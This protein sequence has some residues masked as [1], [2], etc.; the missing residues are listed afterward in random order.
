MLIKKSQ[1]IDGYS[2]DIWL[3]GLNIELTKLFLSLCMLFY[4]ERERG[5]MGAVQSLL[6][7]TAT[8]KFYAIPA[9]I[10]TV[11][12]AL[13]FVNIRM[14]S[15]PTYRV[16]I[17]S[18]VIFSGLLLNTFFNKRLR[19]LQWLSL[20]MLII[21]C[22]TEQLGS[23]SLEGG[24]MIALGTMFVQAF[25]SSLGG[26]YFQWLLQSGTE[27][28]EL[29]LVEKNIFLYTWMVL[30]NF[31]CILFFDAT[32]LISDRVKNNYHPS[33]LPIVIVGALGGFTTSL[34]LQYLDVIAKEFANGLEMIFVAFL[35]W[36]I[37]DTPLSSYLTVAIVFVLG[38]VTLYNREERL[39]EAE[40]P[41]V[42]LKDIGEYSNSD[43][44]SVEMLEVGRKVDDQQ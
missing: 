33:A 24:G 28:V 19:P 25:C 39:R 1:G 38:A 4:T 32:L 30:C 20:A 40:K 6:Q 43:N 29:S 13:A 9:I 37:F 31:C 35:S 42:P 8:A 41:A 5:V 3:M 21:G 27:L 34:L 2:Y 14:L 23:F 11:A 17:N 15:V 12:N 7:K 16:L 18:R 22:T 10:Y 26:V 36:Y 44:E